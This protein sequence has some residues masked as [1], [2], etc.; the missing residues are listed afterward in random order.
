MGSGVYTHARELG[1]ELSNM[2]L[3]PFVVG[4]K[5]ASQPVSSQYIELL[6][7]SSF[8]SK[9]L[10]SKWMAPY[11]VEKWVRQNQRRPSILHGL[12]NLNLSVFHRKSKSLRYVI[13]V[14]DL[15]PLIAPNGVSGALHWQ[16]KMILPKVLAKADAIVTVSE[17]TSRSLIDFFPFV[18][19]KVIHK[20]PNGYRS[21]D[22]N[23]EQY[24]QVIPSPSICNIDK[25]DLKL[26]IV[27]RGESYKRL[28]KIG[29]LAQH[30]KR[31]H[32]SSFSIRLVTDVKGEAIVKRTLSGEL[33]QNVTIY[34]ALDTQ[35][36]QR[37]YV[38]ATVNISFSL[39]EGFGLPLLEA[40]AANTPSV[41]VAGSGSSEYLNPQVSVAVSSEAEIGEWYH[42]I[43]RAQALKF[44][45]KFS[46]T[47]KRHL[48][49]LPSW[50]DAAFR[51]KSLYE[52]LT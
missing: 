49:S 20:I 22:F 27:A 48:I 19:A 41:F 33:K 8:G 38:E 39:Y 50:K 47:A 10:S 44:S 30:L 24:S 36:L 28:E 52:S 3:T 11:L 7:S 21:E 23:A 32:K 18:S 51:L 25:Q 17:W 29:E 40:L 42:A 15:I 26:V 34:K 31:C 35:Q 16:M 5:N 12:S 43:L 4:T 46:E 13:T 1:L 2:G 6:K 45:D 14:H 9:F 37:L